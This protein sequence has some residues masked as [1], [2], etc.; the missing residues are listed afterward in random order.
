MAS[1]MAVRKAGQALS[2]RVARPTKQHARCVAVR[3]SATEPET[4]A[5]AQ[6]P[7][8]TPVTYTF[9]S[10]P[11]PA[12]APVAAG[13]AKVSFGEA[14]SFAGP[15]PETINGR[16][17]MLGVLAALGAEFATGESVFTQFENATPVVLATWAVISLASLVPILRGA[18]QEE[19]FGPLT[20]KA[21]RLNGQAAMLGLAALLLIELIKGSALF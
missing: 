21:E 15:G 10:S 3:A 5:S 19:A 17:A 12:A 6:S 11:I 20:P 18:S 9:E 8:A 4:P 7:A 13:P 1:T 14:M 16:L 2:T